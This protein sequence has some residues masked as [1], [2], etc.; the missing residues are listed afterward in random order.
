MLLA[1]ARLKNTKFV[2]GMA[3]Y[4]GA[5]T[6][7][8]LNEPKPTYKFSVI[9]RRLNHF[10]YIYFAWLII[11]RP[12]RQEHVDNADCRRA[13][14]PSLPPSSSPPRRSAACRPSTTACGTSMPSNS[15]RS[16]A[17]MRLTSALRVVVLGRSQSAVHRRLSLLPSPLGPLCPQCRIDSKAGGRVHQA[18]ALLHAHVQLCHPNLPLRHA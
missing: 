8:V 7:T 11:V 16:T 18:L 12:V 17:P 3:V 5:E 4:T 6:K 15:G 2:I 9:E 14:T 13:T 10:L 1:G